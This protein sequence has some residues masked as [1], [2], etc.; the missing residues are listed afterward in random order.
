MAASPGVVTLLKV[1]WLRIFRLLPHFSGETLDLG[2]PG[3]TMA[4]LSVSL[5]RWGHRFGTR[6]AWRGLL[7]ER[8]FIYRV[9]GGGSRRRGAAG[10]RR[11]ECEDGCAQSGGTMV[12]ST[13][14]LARSMPTSRVKM[15]LRKMV[16]AIY[17]AYAVVCVV[18]SLD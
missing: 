17:R 12:A 1:S 8:C 10:S 4:A 9:E 5:T 11:R 6:H 15:G 13:A 18:S 3:R 2:L 16:A 14:C 7:V